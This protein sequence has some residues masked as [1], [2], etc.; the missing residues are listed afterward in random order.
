MAA[1][2]PPVMAVRPTNRIVVGQVSSSHFRA[3][4]NGKFFPAG[5]GYCALDALTALLKAQP[6]LLM[7]GCAVEVR[8]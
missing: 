5:N 7:E 6:E 3:T 2:I 4:A 1:T 8:S